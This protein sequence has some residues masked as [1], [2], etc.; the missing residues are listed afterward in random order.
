[1]STNVNVYPVSLIDRS[2]K[3]SGDSYFE[4]KHQNLPLPVQYITNIKEKEQ[5]EK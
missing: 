4:K 1:M 5:K 2:Q 3:G